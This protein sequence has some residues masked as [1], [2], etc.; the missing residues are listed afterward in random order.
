MSA[1]Q[2]LTQAQRDRLQTGHHLLSRPEMVRYWLLS[3][4]DRKHIEERRRERNRLGFA[5]Q[6][7]LLRYPGWPLG[8]GEPPPQNLLKFLAKQLE[9]DAVEVSDYAKRPQ[10][11]TDHVQ[12]LARLFRFRQYV[13]P[14]PAMLRE[15]LRGEALDNESA[16]TLVQSALGWLRS[17]RVIVPALTTLETLV[18]SVGSEV[19]RTVYLRMEES[20]TGDQKKTLDGLLELSPKRGSMLGWVRRVPSSCSVSGIL[21]LIRRVLWM[22]D[23][24]VKPELADAIPAARLRQLAA[25]GA[26]HSLS[27]FRRFPDAKRHGILAAFVLYVCQELTDRTFAFHNR[28][29]G[30]IF[31]TA[32]SRQWNHLTASGT[33][34][35]QKLHNHSRLTRALADAHRNGTDLGAAVESVLSWERLEQEAVE[36]SRLT[37]PLDA[38]SYETYRSHYPQLRQYTPKL[39]ETFHF[40]AI[41]ALKPLLAGIETIRQMNRDQVSEVPTDAPRGFVKSKWA[42]YVFAA[43]GIDRCY[44]ELCV[45]FEM[46]SALRSGDL[47]VAGSR[48]YLRFDDYMIEPAKWRRQR[49]EMVEARDPLLDGD[50][51]L[52]GRKADLDRQLKRVCELMQQQQ[53]EDVRLE[54]NKL[55]V[56]P[57]T[58]A[59]PEETEQWA[60][61][62]YELLPRVS[63]T[64]VLEDVCSWSNWPQAFVHLYTGQPVAD[65]AC[66]LTAILAA[67]TNLGKTK[68]ADATEGYSA[69]RLTWVEDWYLREATYA[70]ALAAT[71]ELQGQIPLVEQWGSGRTSSS[72]GQAFPIAFK[73]PVMANI[74]AKYGRDPVAMIYTHLSDRYAP[75]HAQAISSTVRDATYVLDGLLHHDSELQIEEHYTDTA[76]YTDHVFALCHLLGFRF[77]PRI[78]DLGDHRL[79]CFEKPSV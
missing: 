28:L 26:R 32:E 52:N 12:E 35:N 40:E 14:F 19:E 13:S 30:R 20:L 39:L 62:I 42:S 67:A 49:V 9:I 21:D 17:H 41:P 10:T 43:K 48:R 51:Y 63:L 58:R 36:T 61:K 70:R 54:N 71:I 18:R 46:S 24:G 25:R 60:E 27:H 4:E 15:H 72:D 75:Y 34:V 69:D 5:V 47:W 55:V 74:N 31:Y 11:R 1:P 59:V 73:K 68:M 3:E 23:L 66:L 65:K 76:G 6:L 38:A 33:T 44:Y 79:F 8:P 78:R 22:R 45:L 29:L 2:E 16:F 37:R 77:A 64:Q 56:S 50:A 53:L 57:L 7:C